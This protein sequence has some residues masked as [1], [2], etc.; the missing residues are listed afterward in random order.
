ML[1]DALFVYACYP[2][3]VAGP[4]MTADKEQ[5][6]AERLCRFMGECLN[7]GCRFMGRTSGSM[8]RSNSLSPIKESTLTANLRLLISSPMDSRDGDYVTLW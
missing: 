4:A 1:D 7:E 2:N 3:S 6:V 5:I 8:R